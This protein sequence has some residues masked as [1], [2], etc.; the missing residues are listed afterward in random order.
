MRPP[1]I[2][3]DSLLLDEELNYNK[4]NEPFTIFVQGSAGERYA[5]EVTRYDT[6]AN[7]KKA[8]WELE[9]EHRYPEGSGRRA[10]DEA[11]GFKVVFY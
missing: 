7:L 11:E 5:I 9:H 10:R 6:V 8:V 3:P 1:K 4:Y 2:D